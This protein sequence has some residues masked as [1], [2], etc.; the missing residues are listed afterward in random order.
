M[1]FSRGEDSSSPLIDDE[2][3]DEW[4]TRALFIPPVGDDDVEGGGTPADVA[5]LAGFRGRFDLGVGAEV[6]RVT[7]AA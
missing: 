6:S 3:V 1:V 7:S 5:G 4:A 2:T